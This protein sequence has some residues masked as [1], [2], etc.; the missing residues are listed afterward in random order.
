MLSKLSSALTYLY[1][2]ISTKP[3]SKSV[4]A[5]FN[6]MKVLREDGDR[7]GGRN[8]DTHAD[9]NTHENRDPTKTLDGHFTYHLDVRLPIG[10]EGSIV[11]PAQFSQQRNIYIVGA[12]EE[13]KVK[14]L[15]ELHD[16]LRDKYEL[17]ILSEHKGY[18]QTPDGYQRIIL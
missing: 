16:L 3:K 9:R 8:R 11:L 5:E 13:F 14:D 10:A 4:M 15:A 17:S 6:D 7:D 18:I 12:K 2:Y 1:S